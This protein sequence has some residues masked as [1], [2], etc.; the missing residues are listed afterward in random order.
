L[1]RQQVRKLQT[2]SEEPYRKVVLKFLNKLLDPQHEWWK[3]TVKRYLSDKFV[4]CLSATEIDENYD[5]RYKPQKK[6]NHNNSIIWNN[7]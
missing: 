4:E 1:F 5:L 6:K 3:K 2:P 7:K